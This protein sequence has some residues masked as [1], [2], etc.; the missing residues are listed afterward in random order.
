MVPTHGDRLIGRRVDILAPGAAANRAHSR[1]FAALG[2]ATRLSLVVRLASGDR[3]SITELAQGSRLTR[4]AMTK[5]LWTPERAG[6][7]LSSRA[8][9]E[10]LFEL[11]PEPVAAAQRYL[12]DIAL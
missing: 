12:G 7:V 8:G 2:E 11:R 5:H 6:L 1:L 4:Q 10:Q 9:R 3:R